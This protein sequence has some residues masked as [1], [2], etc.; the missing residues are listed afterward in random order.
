MPSNPC[1]SA[2]LSRQFFAVVQNS[3]FR[4]GSP[5]KQIAPAVMSHRAATPKSPS[6]RRTV[7]QEGY[8]A[9]QRGLKRKDNPYPIP[10]HDALVW[11]RG[12][13]DHLKK[14]RPRGKGLRLRVRT[15]PTDVGATRR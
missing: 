3:N 10:S 14:S 7:Q 2:A 11:E 12:W 1:R 4:C 6:P 15:L 13:V 8:S 5:A 9:G